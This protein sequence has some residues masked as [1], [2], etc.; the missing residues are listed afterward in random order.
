MFKYLLL[1]LFIHTAYGSVRYS[2]NPILKNF[3]TADASPQ[4]WADGK[5][6]VYTSGDYEHATN[7]KNMDHYKCYST[8]DMINWEYHGVILSASDLSWGNPNKGFMFAPDAAFKDGI[9]YLY[10][11]HRPING[12]GWRV[13]VATSKKPEGPFYDIGKPIE[14]P[15]HIDPMCFTDEDGDSYLYWGFG[16]PGVPYIAKLKDN[17]TELAEKPIPVDYGANDFFEAAFLHKYKDKYYFTYNQFGTSKACY[18]IG[19]SPYGPFKN[20]G[21]FAESPNGAQSHPGIIK[22]RNKWYYFYHRGDY[23][24]NNIEGSLYRRNVCIDYLYYNND[25][26]I[27]MI[28][29]TEKGVMEEN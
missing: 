9:Y 4:V 13:G 5:L 19:E 29:Y 8:E 28:E 26:S 12:K 24:L 16:R 7:Y 2:G 10:F 17:M 18:A 3:R 27:R 22:Y 21:V 15:D 11:P 6:W 1:I 14:G 20:K 23:K 25:G